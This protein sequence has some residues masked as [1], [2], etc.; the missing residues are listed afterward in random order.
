MY[1]YTYIYTRIHKNIHIYIY[2]LIYIQVVFSM[3]IVPGNLTRSKNEK[4]S[5]PE[6]DFFYSVWFL[7]YIGKRDKLESRE[8]QASK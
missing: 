2:T 7:L 5:T 8:Q 6:E 4:S 1:I 3:Y